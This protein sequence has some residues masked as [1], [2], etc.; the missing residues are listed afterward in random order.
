MLCGS[1]PITPTEKP[2]LNSRCIQLQTC[3]THF[4]LRS[5]AELTVCKWLPSCEHCL[6]LSLIV[7]LMASIEPC[8]SYWLCLG[9][10]LRQGIQ[11]ARSRRQKRH[12]TLQR[13]QKEPCKDEAWRVLVP[14]AGAVPKDTPAMWLS[15]LG[16]DLSR[17]S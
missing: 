2:F 12:Q 16:L 17:K 9:A 13:Q 15:R 11:S 7:S 5:L 1:R 4:P 10:K 6:R 8:K 3:A 14:E